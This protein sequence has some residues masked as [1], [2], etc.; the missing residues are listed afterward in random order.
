MWDPKLFCETVSHQHICVVRDSEV[1]LEEKKASHTLQVLCK[2]T[3]QYHTEWR[4]V[5]LNIQ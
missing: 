4:V 5:R 1:K 3:S 2:C